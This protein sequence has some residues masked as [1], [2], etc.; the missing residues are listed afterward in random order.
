MIRM[1]D[2]QRV[3]KHLKNH[4]SKKV[5]V[6]AE[7]AQEF[8]CAL[9]TFRHQRVWSPK[10][11]KVVPLTP[12]PPPTAVTPDRPPSAAPDPPPSAAPEPVPTPTSA[13]QPLPPA[14]GLPPIAVV[15]SEESSAEVEASHADGT[16][17]PP[18][19]SS[20]ASPAA[21][22][23]ATHG[24]VVVADAIDSDEEEEQQA[25]RAAQ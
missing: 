5:H 20:G 10:E 9:T 23:D 22:L 4:M 3:I 2:G 16:A 7:Y 6:P 8:C 14:T 19:A 18:A 15:G 21:P 25:T 13:A 12:L 11:A 17:T 24:S 1:R